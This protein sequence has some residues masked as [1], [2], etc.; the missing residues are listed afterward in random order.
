[1]EQ[2]ILDYYKNKQQALSKELN[3]YN[4]IN[5]YIAISKLVSFI[6]TIL[7][8]IL[9]YFNE[10]ISIGIIFIMPVL[11][12]LLI[13]FGQRYI[14]LYSYYSALT[15]FIQDETKFLNKDYTV[16][17]CGSEYIDYDHSYSYDLDIFEK[18]SIFHSINRCTTLE[19]EELLK[20]MLL[21]PLHSVDNIKNIQN[22]VKEMAKYRDISHEISSI[23]YKS[24]SSLTNFIA[25]LKED[26]APLKKSTLVLSYILVA[27]T[28]IS[29]ILYGFDVLPSFVPMG[30]FIIQFAIASLFTK[31]TNDEYARLNKAN[32]A[33]ATYLAV[34]SAIKNIDFK[35]DILCDIKKDLSGMYEKI[36][37]LQ[38]INREFD[39]RN[40]G[41]YFLIS[42]GLFL[43]DIFLSN[44]LNKWI[45]ENKNFVPNWSK[46]IA[47][48]D[49]INSLSSYTYNNSD[50]IFPEI[51]NDI[52]LKAENLSHPSINSLKRV[53]NSIEIVKTKKSQKE[54]PLV[55]KQEKKKTAKQKIKA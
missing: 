44:K 53:G 7:F 18:G 33:S 52:I 10:N 25:S 36:N 37:M 19:G 1:M 21:N 11:F 38:K 45:R 9:W 8:L 34:S 13:I 22:A 47:K 48:L 41:L 28:I 55:I 20:D 26:A 50:F 12:V 42:N 2:N 3:K 14:D 5:K 51:N 27:A 43:K 35:S 30:F 54:R 46:T 40:S 29:F 49:V 32:K 15:S 6:L 39:Q 4:S 24:P 23:S 17:R 16:F 31:K